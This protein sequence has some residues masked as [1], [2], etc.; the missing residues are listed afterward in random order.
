MGINPG[1]EGDGLCPNLRSNSEGCSVQDHEGHGARGAKEA[2]L[3]LEGASERLGHGWESCR[4]L[5]HVAL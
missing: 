2:G 5:S 4:L 3:V 1:R